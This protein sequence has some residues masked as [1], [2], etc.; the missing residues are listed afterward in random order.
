MV[1][2]VVFWLGVAI[3]IV[4]LAG[5]MRWSAKRTTSVAG[6]VGF[7][8][9]LIPIVIGQIIAPL[10]GLAG[11]KDELGYFRGIAALPNGTIAVM[12]EALLDL[13]FLALQIATMIAML[14]R[15][16]AFPRWFLGQ[17][18]ALL[19]VF[20]AKGLVLSAALGVPLVQSVQKYEVLD[21]AALAAVS[22]IAA[23]YLFR[24]LRVRNTFTR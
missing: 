9:W 13:A 22:G 16:R 7:G 21:T 2:D 3:A 17:C 24:S 6:P 4:L 23:F 1:G 11:L 12:G 14:R 5:I 19:G 15:Q 8:G 20:A 18:F 10:R